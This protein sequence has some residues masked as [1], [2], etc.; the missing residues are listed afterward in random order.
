MIPQPA[1]ITDQGKAVSV[2]ATMRRGEPEMFTSDTPLTALLD[3]EDGGETSDRSSPIADVMGYLFAG[4]PHPAHVLHRLYLLT[5][6]LEP[7]MLRTLPRLELQ[8]LLAP[9]MNRAVGVPSGSHF[10]RVK[11]ILNGTR[12]ERRPADVQDRMIQHTLTVAYHRQR[13]KSRTPAMSLDRFLRVRTGERMADYRARM[14]AMGAVLRFFFFDGPAPKQTIIRVFALAKS[15]HSELIH[16]MSV[17]QLGAL[18]GVEGATW[19]ER[20]KN[21]LNKFLEDRGAAGVMARFQK[22]PEACEA[23]ARAQQGNRNRRGGEARSA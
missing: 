23:Y 12:L 11:M 22:S 13:A 15:Y 6:E 10:A 16:D 2:H 8:I 18:F 7:A 17:R 21:K 19:S 5:A 14:T 3:R 20:I 1:D 9:A 4:T